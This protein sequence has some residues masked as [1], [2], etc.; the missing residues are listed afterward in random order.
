MEPKKSSFLKHFIQ[1]NKLATIGGGII[2]IF[3]LIAIFAPVM[4]KY[5]PNR[6][7]LAHALLPPCAEHPFGTDNNGRDTFTRTIYGTRISLVI[8]FISVL[9]GAIIGV[10]LGLIAGWFKPTEMIIMRFIDVLLSFPGLIIALTI[11][12]IFGS[13]IQNMIM[14]VAISEIPQFARLTHGQVLSIKEREF[15][16]ASVTIGATD[17]RIM[18]RS[19]FPNIFSTIIVQMSILIPSAIMM[20]A[21]LSFLGLGIRPPTAEWGSMLQ[22][23]VQW[24]RRAPHMMIFPGLA[25]ML[26]V[27]GFNTLG[28][29]LRVELDPKMKNR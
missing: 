27:F 20:A 5:E 19:I 12:S 9:I 16:T 10:T 17:W 18:W 6:I 22:D 26:V 24:F 21:S 1:N 25:L 29:G 11:I 7:D 15:V 14:A 4:T 28:D 2:I 8:G 3:I 13:D 23:S